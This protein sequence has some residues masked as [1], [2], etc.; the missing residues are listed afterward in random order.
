MKIYVAGNG[1]LLLLLKKYNGNPE[2]CPI[3]LLQTFYDMRKQ[4]HESFLKIK[5]SCKEFLLDS[6]AFTFM[7]SGVRVHWK[8][9][10]N[11]YIDFI[12]KYDIQHFF[13]LDLYTLPEVGIEKTI[14]MRRY[15]E[16][17]TG[18][19]SIPV[20]HA[21]MGLEMYRELCREYDYIAIGAS[22]LTEECRWV[23]NKKLLKQMVQI[24]DSYGTK[25]HGLGYQRI[26][27]LNNNKMGFYSVDATSWI[28]SRFNTKYDIKQ[29]NLVKSKCVDTSK[30]ERLKDYL[31]LD[32]H[33]LKV[34]RRLQQLKDMEE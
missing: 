20:F 19:Q 2:K 34:F 26:D 28:G 23:K 24:A 8:T 30:G 3:Y 16:Y 7:N 32:E 10:V 27:N 25:V 14:K 6:G 9:Y 21:C 29:G 18:K 31:Q 12:N 33:N 13:E 17:H 1:V 22:G 11:E 15:I 4:S 5:N